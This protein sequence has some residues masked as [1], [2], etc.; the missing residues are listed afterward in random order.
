MTAATTP[1]ATERPIIFDGESAR[2]N[3][4]GLKWQTRRVSRV[5]P[6]EN[7]YRY[8]GRG[9]CVKGEWR[10]YPAHRG[11]V[12]GGH[13]SLGR[14]PLGVVGD[15]IRVS[16]AVE[17]IAK[18]DDTAD[19]HYL[20]D[21]VRSVVYVSPRIRCPL[22]G[23]YRGRIIP[24][25]WSRDRYQ[26]TRIRVERVQDISEADAVAEGLWFQDGDGTG[27]GSGFKWKGR[28]YHGGNKTDTGWKTFHVPRSDGT[29]DCR[30]GGPSPAQ[31]AFRE[32]WDSLNAKRGHGWDANPWVW[33]YDYANPTRHT[34]DTDDG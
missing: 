25:E 23:R 34:R 1:M 32:R 26:L 29:C 14:C 22:V 7:Y 13:I 21:G 30:V 33:V 20:A 9:R 8:N 5:Q 4:A 17:V 12:R 28:G 2:A 15:W 6:G 31:C 27:P 18:D 16:E 19:I 3:R 24:C 10:V 11:M